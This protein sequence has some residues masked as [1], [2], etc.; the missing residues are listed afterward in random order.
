M[1]ICR[2]SILQSLPIRGSSLN[3]LVQAFVAFHAGAITVKI[4]RGVFA[5]VIGVAD[6]VQRAL[7]V[8]TARD[9]FNFGWITIVGSLEDLQCNHLAQLWMD[10]LTV[11]S[12]FASVIVA[13]LARSATRVTSAEVMD[14]ESLP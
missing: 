12:A 7:P 11:F 9:D 13:S 14:E 8:S 6:V 2:Q 4:A 5:S 10:Q 3:A 1:M